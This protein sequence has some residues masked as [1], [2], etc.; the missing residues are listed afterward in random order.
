MWGIIGTKAVNSLVFAEYL[1]RILWNATRGDDAP[2]E[3]IPSWVINATAVAAVCFVVMLVVGTRSLGTR[4]A[5]ILTIMK[6]SSKHAARMN[7]TN[8]IPL[9]SLR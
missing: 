2:A 9:R 4:A 6:V 3:I 1:N 5:V 7:L 8:Q